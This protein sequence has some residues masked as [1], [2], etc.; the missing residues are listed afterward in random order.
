MPRL[1][2]NE[3]CNYKSNTVCLWED[4]RGYSERRRELVTVSINN[5]TAWIIFSSFIRKGWV[6]FNSANTT[7]APSH[8]RTVC[9][10]IFYIQYNTLW[11]CV[12]LIS[13]NKITLYKHL[14]ILFYHTPTI[15]GK[16]YL[17]NTNWE[18]WKHSCSMQ[19][20]SANHEHLLSLHFY[21]DIFIKSS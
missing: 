20:R 11:N 6:L 3:N 2:I 12:I 8:K 18:S 10:S 19:Y 5:E 21:C 4:T 14:N 1:Y 16:R 15:I 9:A 13:Q 7:R 17:F